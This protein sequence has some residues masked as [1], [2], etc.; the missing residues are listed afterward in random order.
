MDAVSAIQMDVK[1]GGVTYEI[2]SATLEQAKEGR[3][4][5]LR[6]MRKCHPPV[7]RDLSP[8]APH[9]KT[10]TIDPS[11]TG[12][13]IGPG[14]KYIRAAEEM[15]GVETIMVD[16]SGEIEINGPSF[17]AVQKAEQIIH[18]MVGELK[19]GQRIEAVEVSGVKEFGAFVD[20]APGRT[21]L[22]HVSELCLEPV[23]KIADVVKIGDVFDVEV[24]K[25]SSNG[26]CSLSRRAVLLKEGHTVPTPKKP[27][28][29]REK[30]VLKS[31][32][33]AR[34]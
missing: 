28:T 12:L 4:H 17:E 1:V 31:T 30:P 2:L 10:I 14:G 32:P 23:V 25:A 24:L 33:I 9:I 18:L 26:K 8:Y 34:K 6:E 21:G 27:P 11:K 20:L 3:Q 5:I 13:L 22:I 29:L 15:S 7:R 16:Q 19:P